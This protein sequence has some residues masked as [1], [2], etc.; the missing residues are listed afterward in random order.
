MLTGSLC[1]SFGLVDFGRTVSFCC[2]LDTILDVC[3]LPEW[4]NC[5]AIL[6]VSWR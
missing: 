6:F 5:A 4:G 3:D 1:I 2:C